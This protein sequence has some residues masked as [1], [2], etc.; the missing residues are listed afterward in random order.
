M[1]V[2][3]Q[4]SFLPAVRTTCFAAAWIFIFCVWSSLASTEEA[5]R[6][7]VVCLVRSGALLA[8]EIPSFPTQRHPL[9]PNPETSS[10]SQPRLDD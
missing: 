8:G 5:Q 1:L 9:F 6:C 3:L 2:A 10:L 7:D 4:T